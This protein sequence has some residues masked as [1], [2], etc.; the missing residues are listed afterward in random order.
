[1]CTSPGVTIFLTN[2]DQFIGTCGSFTGEVLAGP[3]NGIVGG[4]IGV[5]IPAGAIAFI[6]ELPDS[7]LS[8]SN[9]GETGGPDIVINDKGNI[10]NLGPDDSPFMTILDADDDGVPDASDPHPQSDLGPTVVVNDC[11]SGVANVVLPSGSSIADLVTD[12]F[13]AGGE[14]AVEDL[15]EDLEDDGI[16][17]EDEAEAIEDCAEDDDEDDDDEDD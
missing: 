17:S 1:M 3:V 16:L 15:V 10:I 9:L 6:E 14:D 11:D 5:T 12:A 4:N 8:I 7:I 2:G 13:N